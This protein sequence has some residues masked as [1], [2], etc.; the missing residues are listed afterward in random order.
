M[1]T[2]GVFILLLIILFVGCVLVYGGGT[3]GRRSPGAK[4]SGPD[5]TNNDT[6]GGNVC[7]H[8]GYAQSSQEAQF[9]GHCGK[10]LR[11]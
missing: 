2:Y 5:A 9:C 11:D 8:C 10:Q 7:P 4:R 1:M 3:G 6:G